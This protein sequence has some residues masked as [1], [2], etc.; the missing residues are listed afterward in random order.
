MDS[1]FRKAFKQFTGQSIVDLKSFLPQQKVVQQLSHSM[2]NSYSIILREHIEQSQKNFTLE[3]EYIS[4]SEECLKYCQKEFNALNKEIEDKFAD[5]RSKW[6]QRLTADVM[7]PVLREGGWIEKSDEGYRLKVGHRSKEIKDFFLQTLHL[8]VGDSEKNLVTTY[9]RATHIQKNGSNLWHQS[10]ISTPVT[11]ILPTLEAGLRNIDQ[12]VITNIRSSLYTLAQKKF[13]TGIQ[14]Q[15]KR[16]YATEAALFNAI[17]NRA[18]NPLGLWDNGF[19]AFTE[20]YV[21]F[22]LGISL[23]ISHWYKAKWEIFSRG[24]SQGQLDLFKNKK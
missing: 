2:N 10:S 21:D 3:S 20:D 22:C 8:M 14:K 11:K 12:N 24:F 1:N 23:E 9:S 4:E 7:I 13:I 5:F 16:Y 6:A 19:R 15:P 18:W 17:G